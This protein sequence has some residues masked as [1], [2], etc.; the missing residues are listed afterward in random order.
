MTIY[1]N[2]EV[3]PEDEGEDSKPASLADHEERI[4]DLEDEVERL[5][6]RQDEHADDMHDLIREVG[7]IRK[8]LP[9]ATGAVCVV[10]LLSK[11]I[12]E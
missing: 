9:W 3:V 8:L 6:R 7:E 2:N 1:E 4:S 5:D 11:L 10:Q 12:G